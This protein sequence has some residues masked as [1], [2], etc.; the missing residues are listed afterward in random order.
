MQAIAV[1]EEEPA[2]KAKATAYSLMSQLKM[3]ADLSDDCIFWGEKAIAL[4]KELAINDTLSYA[5]GN[6]G[7]IKIRIPG[8]Y[9]EGLEL[10]RQ[11]LSLALQHSFQDYAGMAYTNLGYNGLVVKDYALA[12]EAVAYGIPY[13]EE[14]DL[15][16]WRL[17][18]VTINAKLTLDTGDWTAA[19]E[20][21]TKL[22]EDEKPAKIIKIFAL[23][24]LANIDM[25]RGN[26]VNILTRLIEAKEKAFETAEPQRIIQALTAFLEYEW[27]TGEYFIENETLRS[28][29]EL[30][31]KRGNIFGNSEFAFW[32]YKARGQRL[33]LKEVYEAFDI[34]T[35][36]KAQRAA[37]LW[38]EIGCPYNKALALFAGTEDNK[39]EA[40]GIVQGLGADAVYQ[41]MKMEMRSSGIKNI[42][43]GLRKSTQANPAQL[44]SRELDVLQLMNEG[45]QNKEIA[46][47]LFI[48]AKTVEHHISS[49]LFK[50]DSTT[51]AKALNEAQRLSI[52]K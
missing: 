33:Q 17:Y 30:I 50:L 27:I 48:S 38:N 29:I 8:S 51:R 5:L 45:L 28:A 15:D 26:E 37:V 47:K 12:K 9:L 2:S 6:V 23:T 40:I 35:V 25:R 46:G 22:A 21:S 4:S 49:I 11:S 31:S 1:L 13:C 16:L 3:L 32:L 18:L 41:K 14:N 43:R 7:S 52:I 39:K 10:L 42:P 20:L 19:Y 34:G 24:I 36:A 44:T